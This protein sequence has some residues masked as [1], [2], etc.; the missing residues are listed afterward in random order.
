MRNR[1][2]S[3]VAFALL[4]FSS[5]GC[6][7]DVQL[8]A[9]PKRT[10]GDEAGKL[11]AGHAEMPAGHPPMDAAPQKPADAG[12]TNVGTHGETPAGHSAA[13]PG[14][15]AAGAAGAAKAGSSDPFADEEGGAKV[16]A[17][18][19]DPKAVA[20]AGEIVLG[21]GVVAP[22]GPFSL[23]VSVVEGP[24]G[25]MPVLTKKID[26]PTFPAKFELKYGDNPTMAVVDPSKALY[27]RSSISTTGDVMRATNKTNSPEPLKLGAVDFKLVLKP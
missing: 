10:A 8:A 15:A 22:T 26:S 17:P 13:N 21:E 1:F 18:K 16:E 2:L 7:D 27:L 6:G 14:A 4:V 25:R 23:F 11:P 12:A 19:Q 9:P 20:I 24:Q 3:G 5:A